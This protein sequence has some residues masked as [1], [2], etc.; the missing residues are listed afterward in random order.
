MQAHKY[1]LKPQVVVACATCTHEH[2]EGDCPQEVFADDEAVVV[3]LSEGLVIRAA[4][5]SR[6]S[7]KTETVGHIVAGTGDIEWKCWGCAE[8]CCD[9]CGDKTNARN[10]Y[11]S[12]SCIVSHM[13]AQARRSQ[14]A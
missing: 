11:C 14:A 5:C 3:A 7:K 8:S 13:R 9:W 1:V 2:V 12:S 4:C 6:C 10:R